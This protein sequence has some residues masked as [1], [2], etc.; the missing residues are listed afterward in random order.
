MKKAKKLMNKPFPLYDDLAV[1]CEESLQW[2]L[3]LRGHVSRGK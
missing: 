3:G 2:A 1:L